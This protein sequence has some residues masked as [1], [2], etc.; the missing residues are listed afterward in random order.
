MVISTNSKPGP[1]QLQPQQAK[2]SA[3]EKRILVLS[4]VLFVIITVMIWA[5]YL[6]YRHPPWTMLFCGYLLLNSSLSLVMN[7]EYRQRY[8]HMLGRLWGNWL[9]CVPREVVSSLT[10]GMAV[11]KAGAGGSRT[12]GP[13]PNSKVAK[14]PSTALFMR[15][16]DVGGCGSQ[17]QQHP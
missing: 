2:L 10:E 7:S 14:S 6:D 17:Q 3:H 1:Q 13:N 8:L 5:W 15:R 9:C 12:A 11:G 16:V 4:M